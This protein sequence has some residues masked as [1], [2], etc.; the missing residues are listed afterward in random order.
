MS[1]VL[2]LAGYEVVSTDL[3]NRG[4][5]QSRIDFLMEQRLLAPEIVTNPPFH[6]AKQFLRHALHL[7]AVKIVFLLR[8]AWLEGLERMDIFTKHPPA[9]VLVSSRRI[10]FARAGTDRGAGGSSMVPFAFFVWELDHAGAT[11]LKWFDWEAL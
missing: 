1:K 3:I 5:G 7:R 11:E 4:Y 10:P 2:E 8:L 6:L 9:R